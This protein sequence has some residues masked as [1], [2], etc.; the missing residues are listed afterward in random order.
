MWA[1][2][3]ASDADIM[4]AF[5]TKLRGQ[6]HRFTAPSWARRTV[7]GT[8]AGTVLVDGASQAGAT[9]AVKGATIGTTLLVGDFLGVNGELHLVTANATAD[10]AGKL[11]AALAWP[12]RASPADNAAVTYA[13]PSAKFVLTAN[14]QEWVDELAQLTT[15]ALEAEEAFS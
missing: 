8:L 1:N 5:V 4:R 3:S 7:R 10:G 6:A 9:L 13:L 12:L 15:F 14:R 2:L 11:T